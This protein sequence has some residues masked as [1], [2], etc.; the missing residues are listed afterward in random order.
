M[1]VIVF[2][3][4]LWR[5]YLY[6]THCVICTDHKSLQYIFSQKEMNMCQRRWQEL[7]KD[8]DLD[9]LKIAQLKALPDEHLKSEQMG[10]RKE[11]LIDDS[12]RLKTYR[13]RVW[14]SVLGGLRDLIL[15]EAHKSRLSVHPGSTKIKCQTPSCWL[16]AGEKKFAGPKIVQQTAKKVAIALEKLKAARDRQKMYADPRQRLVTFYI[17]RMCVFKSVS[18]E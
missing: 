16:E 8:Y 1:D 3:L 9:R 11:E 14:A 5:H 18:V 7:F 12:R 17:E 15:N 13:E 2:A 4:K 10:K 6:G